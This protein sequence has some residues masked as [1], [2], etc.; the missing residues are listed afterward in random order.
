MK[1]KKEKVKKVKTPKQPG[2]VRSKIQKI[3]GPITA[4]YEKRP[5]GGILL[6]AFVSYL[7]IEILSRHSLLKA[8]SFMV[9]KPHLFAY[10]ALIIA[11][12]LSI[13]LFFRKRTFVTI[14]ITT[15]WLLLGFINFIVLFFR[16]TPFSFT[17]IMVLGSVKSIISQY[18]E[19]WQLIVIIAFFA[20][21]ILL[22]IHRYHRSPKWKRL[23]VK[24]AI[25][26]VTLA[27]AVAYLTFLFSSNG[28]LLR[29]VYNIVDAYR[30]QGFVIM[31]SESVFVRGVGKPDTYSARNVKDIAKMLGIEDTST[32]KKSKKAQQEERE[33]VIQEASL[34]TPNIIY[35]Q[36]ESFFDPNHLKNFTFSGNPV[37]Y[38]TELKENYT[39]GYLNVP[40]FGA[41]TVNT[42]FEILTGMN[43]DYFGPGEYPFS[44]ILL[45]NTCE[46]M[47][48]NLREKGYVSHLIHNNKG[49]FY[50]R[51]QVYPNL[52]FDTFTSIEYMQGVEINPLGWAKDKILTEQILMALDSTEGQDLVYTVS[53]QGHGKYPE[54]ELEGYKQYSIKECGIEDWEE[55]DITGFEYYMNQISQMDTFLR[56]LTT[57]LSNRD[58]PCVLVLYG[59][60]LPDFAFNAEDMD[61]DTLYQTEYVMWSNFLLQQQDKDLEAYQLSA[62]IM[63]RIGMDNGVLTKLHQQREKEPNAETYQD[64]LKMLEYDMLYGNRMIYNGKNPYPKADTQF[65]TEEILITDA[66]YKMDT[67][68]LIVKGENFTERSLVYINDKQVPHTEFIMPQMLMVPDIEVEEED[69]IMVAQ[70]TQ[71]QE[72]L[73]TTEEF[74]ILDMEESSEEEK[75]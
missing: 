39:S 43:L 56:D 24:G 40:S 63:E 52:G 27:G 17:D 28:V 60:H 19:V 53:V 32:K 73:S 36:L 13:A 72:I 59:D 5:V 71:D 61:N 23:P 4:M 38:Y 44:T 3:T 46:T 2:P 35:L 22:L 8:L 64:D 34:A 47:A 65:G 37:S 70:V 41:G 26:L 11:A 10:N 16:S 9:T 58:E 57:A 14:L 45:D 1:N 12:T 74:Y 15:I 18:L 68:T 75:E 49:S 69:R 6:I 42:E 67:K 51:N 25:S 62:Y 7:L 20:L 48:Y 29:N 54:E 33:E 55:S 30:Q 50:R 66:I 21:V 31:F